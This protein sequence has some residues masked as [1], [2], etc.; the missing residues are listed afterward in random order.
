MT[1]TSS[2]SAQQGR[3][4]IY[5]V[6]APRASDAVGLALRDAFSGH[7]SLP[8]DMAALLCRLNRHELRITH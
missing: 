4:P 7:E 5:R 2:H 3:A 8:E 1:R 6:E